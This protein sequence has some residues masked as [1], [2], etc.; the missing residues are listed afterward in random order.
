MK[1]TVRTASVL[2]IYNEALKNL[3]EEKKSLKIELTTLQGSD[4]VKRVATQGR[5]TIL[6]I[7]GRIIQT[8]SICLAIS[9]VLFLVWDI[10][11]R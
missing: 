6:L 3:S 2:E 10:L 7:A 1:E 5:K 4:A 11:L 9:M 8:V